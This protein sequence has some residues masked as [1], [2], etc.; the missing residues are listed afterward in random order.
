MARR[1]SRA[2]NV[3]EMANAIGEEQVTLT[4]SNSQCPIHMLTEV[5][6]GVGVGV[7]VNVGVGVGVCGGCQYTF[8]SVYA[9]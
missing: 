6:I 4:M 8:D 1:A 9:I 3:S 5:G 7:G 2:V